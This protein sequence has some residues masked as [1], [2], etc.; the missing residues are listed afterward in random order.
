MADTTLKQRA[1]VQVRRIGFAMMVL[2]AI[3][4]VLYLVPSV[5]WVWIWFKTFPAPIR[6][7]LGA[8]GVGL[9]ILFLNLLRERWT[10]RDADRA[11]R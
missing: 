5:R 6:F 8:S 1:S 4:I 9:V 10:D 7:G 2:G 3:I 11:L